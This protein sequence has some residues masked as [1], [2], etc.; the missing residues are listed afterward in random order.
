MDSGLLWSMENNFALLSLPQGNESDSQDGQLVC[1][2]FISSPGR[3][4]L[5]LSAP[6]GEGASA[7]LH[8][9]IPDILWCL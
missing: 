5:L 1:K 8:V 4:R 7:P 2:R 9:K 3:H 6:A